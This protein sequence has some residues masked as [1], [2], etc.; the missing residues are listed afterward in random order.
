MQYGD[1]HSLTLE[2]IMLLRTTVFKNEEL[3]R[4]D[5]DNRLILYNSYTQ[6]II[7]KDP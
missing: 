3:T 4:K 2:S 1:C 6:R 7:E 5:T